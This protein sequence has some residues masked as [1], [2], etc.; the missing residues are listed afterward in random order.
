[1]NE[2]VILVDKEDNEI[3]ILD[4]AG[5]E[6]KADAIIRMV[7]VLLTDASGRILLQRRRPDIERYPNYWTVSCTGA[8]HPG[9]GYVQ[10]AQR[11]LSDELG[12]IMGV[13]MAR[14]EL[15]TLPGRASYMTALFV[16]TVNDLSLVN[17]DT[18]RV[19]EVR[20]L[21]LE[22]ARQGYLLTPTAEQMLAWWAQHGKDFVN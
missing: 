15:L 6:T 10:A 4:R 3:G 22:E 1:M 13:K 8:V 17:L 7:Y 12:L 19:Q 20:W 11:K 16:G 21:S 9:E 18:A 5:A 2:P 14:K